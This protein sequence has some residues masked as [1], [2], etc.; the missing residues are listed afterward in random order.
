MSCLIVLTGEAL[1]IEALIV[2]RRV[3]GEE[4]DEAD[5]EEVEEDI[6]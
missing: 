6:I 3:V 4:A 1:N 2:S 5:E